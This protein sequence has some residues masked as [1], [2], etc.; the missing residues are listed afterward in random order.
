M[1]NSTSISGVETEVTK[2]RG[3]M[4]NSGSGASVSIIDNTLQSLTRGQSFGT[5]A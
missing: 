5:S 3:L 4:L 1:F 2:A